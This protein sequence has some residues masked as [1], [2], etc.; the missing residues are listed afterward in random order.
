MWQVERHMRPTLATQVNLL[1]LGLTFRKID[2]IKEAEIGR[3]GQGREDKESERERES[4]M[5]RGGEKV[6]GM[7]PVQC[8][9][10]EEESLHSGA[11]LIKSLPSR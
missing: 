3:K 6:H 4:A 2:R 11:R 10:L 7:L 8:V 1:P 5:K 9:K